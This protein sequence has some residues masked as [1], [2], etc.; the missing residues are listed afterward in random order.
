MPSPR[1]EIFQE[2]AKDFNISW[3]FPIC[4]GSIDGKHI[5]IQCPQNAG[6]QYLNY[7][8]YHP[9]VLLAVEDANLKFLTVDVRAYGKKK[10]LVEFSDIQLC[11]RYTEL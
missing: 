1:E 6:I 9:I 10:A 2:I 3:N 4:V 5:R 8:Q 11:I 7:R